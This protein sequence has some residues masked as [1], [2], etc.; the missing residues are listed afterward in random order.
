VS[1]NDST[2]VSNIYLDG[3][4]VDGGWD[5]RNSYGSGSTWNYLVASKT[6]Y[7]IYIDS[8]INGAGNLNREGS[9]DTHNLLTDLWVRNVAGDGMRILG[10]GEM[11]MHHHRISNCAVNGMYL[12][13]GDNWL[14]GSTISTCGSEGLVVSAGEQRISNVKAWY[15]GMCKGEEVPGV[16][17]EFPDASGIASVGGTN[18]TTQDTWGPGM[19]IEGVSIY[20]QGRV[21]NAGGGRLQQFGSGYQGTRTKDRVAVEIGNLKDSQVEV[22]IKGNDLGLSTLPHA[23]RFG[24]SAASMNRINI[25]T[26]KH[27][28]NPYLHSTLIEQIT[29]YSNAKRHNVVQSQN[30]DWLHGT[31]TAAQLQDIAHDVNVYK[32]AGMMVLTDAYKPLWS[33]GSTAGSVWLDAAGS[34]VYTPV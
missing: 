5:L 12:D 2:G 4:C 26:Y 33:A 7:G 34:T 16:G 8:P 1:I 29:G 3:F 17:V 9:N 18:I 31:K 24:S 10:R 19:L 11:L 28:V 15:I 13:S 27:A 22:Q 21:D 32:R 30:G 6:Q 25:T 14:N 20:V 23:V